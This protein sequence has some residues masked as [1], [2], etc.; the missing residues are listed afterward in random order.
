VDTVTGHVREIVVGR[1]EPFNMAVITADWSETRVPVLTV[2]VTDVALAATLTEVGTDRDDAALLTSAITV[3]EATAFERVTVQVVFALAGRLETAHCRLD[4]VAGTA[5]E[6]VTVREEPF[7]LAVMTA[8]G[9]A[10]TAP[11]LALAVKVMEEAPPGTVKDAGTVNED[12]ALLEIVT[13]A[14]AEAD[15]DRLTVQ[16]VLAPA[17]RL[18]AAHCSA[19]IV[20]RVTRATVVALDE[21]LREAV[22]VAV[23]S[24]VKDLVVNVNVPLP[25]PAGIAREVGTVR[26]DELELRPTVPPPVPLRITVQLPE[27]PGPNAPG[28]HAIELTVVTGTTAM[29]PP[30]PVTATRSPA[31]E[32]AKVL[33]ILTGTPT[34]PARVTETVAR[35]PSWIVVPFA[36]HATHLYEPAPALQDTVLPAAADA[37]PAVTLTPAT[38]VGE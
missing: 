19:E 18:A 21:P 8:D 2:N 22:T 3:L 9:S 35:T 34:P 7:R 14:P 38:A 12:G 10:A 20:G 5:S 15:F 4:R 1:E 37:G 29:V 28:T 33:L 36:P 11:A 32:A 17:A 6:M 27:V 31:A 30:T 25:D 13:T 23:W 26:S 24:D 16:L